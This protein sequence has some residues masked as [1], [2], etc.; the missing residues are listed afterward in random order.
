MST[1]SNKLVAACM[2]TAISMVMYGCGGGGSSSSS[3]EMMDDDDMPMCAEGET[4]TPPNCMTPPTE[5]EIAAR[6]AEATNIAHAIGSMAALGMAPRLIT[7]NFP[8]EERGTLTTG[9][10]DTSIKES[11]D[12]V[13]DAADLNE[14]VYTRRATT[15]GPSDTFVLYND[16][17]PAGP[18]DYVEYYDTSPTGVTDVDPATGELTLSV[19]EVNDAIRMLITGDFGITS[20]HQ[21]IPGPENNEETADVDEAMVEVEGSFQGISG[22][23]SC[24]S[25]CSVT[26]GAMG[27]L[28]ALG[29]E[30]TFTPDTE[31]TMLADLEVAGVV[32][33]TDYLV[34]GYWLQESAGG[35]YSFRSYNSGGTPY[36]NMTGVVETATY[37]G[38]AT[39]L[40]MRKTF[41]TDGVS[42]TTTPEVGG[43]FTA[44]VMLSAS[45]GGGTV[46]SNDQFSITGMIDNFKDADGEMIHDSWIVNLM[47]G[48]TNNNMLPDTNIQSDGSFS[49]VTMVT[50]GDPGAFNGQFYGPVDDPS[51]GAIES[52]FQPTGAS[53][54]FDAHFSNG[55]ARGGF[56]ATR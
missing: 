20:P 19:A 39:G 35:D 40:Y 37:T 7:D 23:Y 56:A 32:D 27:E 50:G 34:F 8:A 11:T 44:D 31:T 55:H 22:T 54:R 33:D 42:V 12:A 29:G 1:L 28:T 41:E 26:S 3:T 9:D 21:S 52:N 46:A 5:A 43:Q 47:R 16:I 45:F 49:G 14:N 25:L 53:G 6:V 36:N 30:W 51:T 13:I 18:M 24:P 48:D 17:Q 10:E 38:T 2:V 4:G 15:N